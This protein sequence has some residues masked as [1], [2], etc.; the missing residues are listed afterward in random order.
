MFCMS[1]GHFTVSNSLFHGEAT[2]A[3]SYDPWLAIWKVMLAWA[4]NSLHLTTYNQ[5]CTANS[6]SP[7]FPLFFVNLRG[8]VVRGV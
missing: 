1:A 3:S 2:I 8:G 4:R 7:R 5:D 6:P